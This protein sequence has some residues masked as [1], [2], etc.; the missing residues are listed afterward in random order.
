MTM[1]PSSGP[2]ILLF[3]RFKSYWRNIAISDY[4]HGVKVLDISEALLNTSNSVKNF[5]LKQLELTH[6]RDDNRELLELTML[7]LGGVPR[8]GVQFM[9]PGAMHRARFMSRLIYAL[10]IFVFR[11][12]GFK[13]SERE[14]NSLG[15]FCTFGVGVYVK[16]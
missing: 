14:L 6:Q 3:K 8:H 9:K 12:A 2:E 13:Q 1:G 4:K 7:F 11:D 15:E 10:K 5:V 16:S